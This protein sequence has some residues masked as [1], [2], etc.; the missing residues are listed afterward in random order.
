M[1]IW[2][3][4][5][6]IDDGKTVELLSIGMVREDGSTYY[7]EPAETDRSRGCE[8]VQ[9]NVI[10]PLTGPVMPR[11]DIAYD[12]LEFSGHNPEFWAYFASYD[13]VALC[14]LYGRMMD[15]PRHWPMMPMDVQQLRVLMGVAQLPK[16][17]STAHNALNDAIWTRQ[18]WQFLINSSSDPANPLLTKD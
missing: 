10:P 1:R 12:I 16:Q 6:F 3:D 17:E 2:F 7:A 4:T 8:W 14:Q 15:L 9:K 18:A 13:W 11:A 5:E